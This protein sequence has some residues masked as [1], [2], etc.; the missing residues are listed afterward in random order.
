[1][2]RRTNRHVYFFVIGI[3]YL[4]IICCVAHFI[5]NHKNLTGT[6]CLVSKPLSG[7]GLFLHAETRNLLFTIVCFSPSLILNIDL[8]HSSKSIFACKRSL[9]LFILKSKRSV[10]T[11]AK[12]L[13]CCRLHNILYLTKSFITFA[14]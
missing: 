12:S 8:G 9:I 13:L 14:N 5:F 4:L 11:T 7:L 6:F 10:A 2:K 1:L 3:E